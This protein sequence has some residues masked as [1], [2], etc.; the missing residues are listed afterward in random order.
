MES[1][2]KT[3]LW[4]TVAG[5]ALLLVAIAGLLIFVYYKGAEIHEEA[6]VQK[7]K[8]VAEQIQ[9]FGTTCTNAVPEAMAFFFKTLEPALNAMQEGR[10]KKE[11]LSVLTSGIK[12]QQEFLGHCSGKV[13]SVRDESTHKLST[14]LMNASSEFASVY[15]YFDAMQ[16]SACDPMCQQDFVRRATEASGKLEILLRGNES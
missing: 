16:H 5:V 6:S 10:F 9:R 8:D 7:Q 14:R 15:V 3:F 1:K 4:G 11:Q 2:T 12:N 13:F